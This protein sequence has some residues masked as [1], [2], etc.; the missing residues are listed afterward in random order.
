MIELRT[1]AVRKS[2][3]EPDEAIGTEMQ[4][5]DSG[6]AAEEVRSCE[7]CANFRVRL[8]LSGRCL[9]H[10]RDTV[11]CIFGFLPVKKRNERPFRN[12]LRS[13]HEILKCFREAAEC[14]F[15]ESE[16]RGIK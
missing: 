16:K 14:L 13:Q 10:G 12:V 5:S 6:S 2:A 7:K 4:P 3:A 9:I 1:S 15:Y 8:P 11:A